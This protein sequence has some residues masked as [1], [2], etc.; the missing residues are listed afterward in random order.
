[1]TNS[2]VIPM[3]TT[4]QHWYYQLVHT[5]GNAIGNINWYCEWILPIVLVDN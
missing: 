2:L 1:M 5:S 4:V 3:T